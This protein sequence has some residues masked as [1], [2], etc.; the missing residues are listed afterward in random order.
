[1]QASCLKDEQKQTPLPH[2]SCWN[3]WQFKPLGTP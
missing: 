3:R 1:V 2:W